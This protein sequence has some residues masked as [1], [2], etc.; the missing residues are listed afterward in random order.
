[1]KKI[2]QGFFFWI[3]FLKNPSKLKIFLARGPPNFPLVTCLFGTKGHGF[4]IKI[5]YTLKC[6][7]QIMSLFIFKILCLL[8]RLMDWSKVPLCYTS[9][10]TTVLKTLFYYNVG[11]SGNL[12]LYGDQIFFE[13]I[14]DRKFF[15][16]IRLLSPSYLV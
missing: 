4:L 2:R 7:L 12:Y 5:F 16:Q 3:L 13:K 11:G 9:E 15:Y 10:R 14:E 1:M 8:N 6:F